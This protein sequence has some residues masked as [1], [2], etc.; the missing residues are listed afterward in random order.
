[1]ALIRFGDRIGKEGRVSLGASAVIFDADRMKVLLTKRADNG[2]WCLPSGK[3]E[4]GESIEEACARE[5][6]EETGLVVTLSRLIGLYST[7]H[8][9]IEYA[10]GNKIQV[11]SGCF[12]GVVESGTLIT[13]DET[14]DFGYFGAEE[15]AK[16]DVMENHLERIADAFAESPIPF[17]R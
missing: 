14:T 12:E 1:M 13:S 17:L 9:L 11:V 5:V 10:D 6:L 3:M 8:Q 16:M 7:P 2:R 4:P 15:I